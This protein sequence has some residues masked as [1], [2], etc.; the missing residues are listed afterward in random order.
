MGA[1][2]SFN[3]LVMR[4]IKSDVRNPVEVPLLQ[5]VR[6]PVFASL[7]QYACA[8]PNESIQSTWSFWERISDTIEYTNFLCIFMRKARQQ[9]SRLTEIANLINYV[10]RMLF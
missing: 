6:N 5:Y 8:Q 4:R 10:A 3:N 1:T 2:E 7:F 9:K